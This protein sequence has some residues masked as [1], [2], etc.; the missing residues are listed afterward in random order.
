MTTITT[1]TAATAEGAVEKK[2]AGYNFFSY[3]CTAFY[4]VENRE[5]HVRL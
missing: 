2:F 3:F 4:S 1:P 5:K